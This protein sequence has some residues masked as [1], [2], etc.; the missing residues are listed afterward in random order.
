MGAIEIAREDFL[1]RIEKVLEKKQINEW[2]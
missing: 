2:K 1:E